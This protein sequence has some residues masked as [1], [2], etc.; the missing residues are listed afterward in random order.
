MHRGYI[1]LY[2]LLSCTCVH[3]TYGQ[4]IPLKGIVWDG[5][6]PPTTQDLL[7][8][9]E[10]GVEAVRLPIITDH[11]LF[12]VADTLGLQLF[13]DLPIRFLPAPALLDTLEYA[14]NQLDLA[15]QRYPSNR[16]AR[17]FGISTNSDTSNPQ[18]CEYFK[19]LAA[20]APDLI[21][22]YTSAFIADDQ[23]YS[24]VDLV[25]L[26]GRKD[27]DPV[28]MIKDW[29]RPTP[30]G[31]SS[32]GK[33]VDPDKFGLNHANSPQSQARFLENHLPKLLETNAEVIFVY[34][35][36]DIDDTSSQWGLM[37]VSGQERPAL[38]VLR[39]IYTGTQQIFAFDYGDK[40]IQAASWPLI[41]S[42]ITCLLIALL[43]L[44]YG[45]F[46]NL[47]WKYT[48]NTPVNRD[49]LYH[50]SILPPDISFIYVIAQGILLSAVVLVLIE[51]FGDL[52]LVKA[53]ASLMNPYI[54]NQISNLTSNNYLL[55]LVVVSIY[56][57][58]NLI[59]Y[60]L[61]TLIVRRV[62][63]ISIEHFFTISA[64]NHTPLGAMLPMVMIASGLNPNQRVI[65]A[66]I[67]AFSWVFLNTLCIFRS[68]RS[69]ATLTRRDLGS[70]GVLSLI[71]FPLLLGI[72]F[73][74]FLFLPST[75][76][77]L[78]FWWNLTFRA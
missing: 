11:T 51:A 13:Q 59:S 39:G 48:L 37:D 23:C 20:W 21:L 52:S 27:L 12:Y 73:I 67:L 29:S 70:I 24:D 56:L 72:G 62:Q 7:K 41:L 4:T 17:H 78:V 75:K 54:L 19:E 46:A 57:I 1:L 58:T 64:M 60:S 53:I 3:Y 6:Q 33:K 14:K 77:Y 8:I 2:L 10:A 31:F 18:A 36:K 30:I 45:R 34:R 26:D 38:D 35:W 25:L 68:V 15:R 71:A 32:V 40:P 66:I 44:W 42:W 47:I 49:T 16:S 61:S 74:L 65:L 28:R 9:H 22:Y 76:E 50:K 69:F 43:C 5:P 63:G 55:V